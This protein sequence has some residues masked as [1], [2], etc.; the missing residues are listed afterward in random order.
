MSEERPGLT[1]AEAHELFSMW[2]AHVDLPNIDSEHPL[3]VG[4]E[5]LGA[6][7]CADHQGHAHDEPECADLAFVSSEY[8]EALEGGARQLR[9]TL[10]RIELLARADELEHPPARRLY[11]VL[12]AIKS[13]AHPSTQPCKSGGGVVGPE[14]GICCCS[15]CSTELL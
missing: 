2:L 7:Q 3:V 6:A 15:S 10:V 4:A 11:E 1:R 9:E 12:G 8:V 14:I 5:K 13:L